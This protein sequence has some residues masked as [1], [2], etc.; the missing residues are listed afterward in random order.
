M[1]PEFHL[2]PGVMYKE[3][4]Q[5]TESSNLLSVLDE[6][7]PDALA[8]GRVGLLGLDT[9]LLEHDALGVGRAT[10]GRRLV[11]GSEE[12]LLELEIGPTSLATMVAQLA[13]GVESS[14]LSLSHCGAVKLFLL[15]ICA[16]LESM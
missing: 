1:I 11:R 13:R 10:E 16:V 12:A 15:A 3:G 7:D 9:D 8:D 2:P 14:R 6:L 5:R 4:V